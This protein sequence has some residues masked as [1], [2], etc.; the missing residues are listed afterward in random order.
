MYDHQTHTLWSSLTGEPVLG[1]LVGKKIVLKVRPVV[2][3]TWEKWRVR[4]SETTVLSPETGHKRDYQENRAYRAYL[5]SSRTMFPVA[6]RDKR[7]QAKDWVFG[8]RSCALRKAYP[9]KI[10]EKNGVVNDTFAGKKLVLVSASK[11]KTVRAFARQSHTFKKGDENTLI[12]ATGQSWRITEDALISSISTERLERL[13]GHLAFWFAWYAFFPET[14]LWQP[15][16][17]VT[18]K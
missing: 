10:F 3:T 17:A 13:P 4:H 2:H 16:S 7:L 6:W 9:L 18:K 8:V 11:D 1:P 12:D 15:A 5:S 14:K